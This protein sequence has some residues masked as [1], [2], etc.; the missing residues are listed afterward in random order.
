MGIFDRFKQQDEADTSNAQAAA[1]KPG[2]ASASSEKKASDSKKSHKKTS[3]VFSG[4]ARN[5]ILHPLVTEKA[6]ELTGMSKY[7]FVVRADANRVEVRNAVR[8]MYNV[9]PTS[10][11]IIKMRGKHVRFGRTL[12][13]RKDWKKAIVSFPKGTSIDAYEGV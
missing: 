11:N 5:V 1:V 2:T 9:N 10:V 3:S 12:G 8:K 13:Q 6:A 4:G 7:V